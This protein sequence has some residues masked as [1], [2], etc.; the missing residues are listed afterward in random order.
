MVFAK[1]FARFYEKHETW[2]IRRLVEE[3]FVPS[4]QR[5]SVLYS[6]LTDFWRKCPMS[7]IIVN[8][9]NTE[10]HQRIFYF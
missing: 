10:N 1:N 2:N 4:T 8:E 5:P 7:K 9:T 6:R 3:T